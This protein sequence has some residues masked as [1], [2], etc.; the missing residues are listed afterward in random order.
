[1]LGASQTEYTIQIGNDGSASW[2]VTQ[3][4]NGNSSIE[5]PE[6]LQNRITLLVTASENA[7]GRTMT[8]SVD[9][10]TFTASGSYV[11]AEYKFQWENFSRIEG[12]QI[13]IGDVFQAPDFFSQL[14]GDGAVYMGYPPE[15]VVVEPILPAPSVQNDSIQSLGWLGTKDFN[16]NTRI[17]LEEK[18][19]TTGLFGALEESVV[20]AAI[21]G[22]IA[23]GSVGF[24]VFRYNKRKK[25]IGSEAAEP[26]GFPE[27][28]SDEERTVKLIKSSGGSLYQ[29]A[30]TDQFGFSKAK[31]SQ[32][33]AALEHEGI[34][35]RYKK[36][37]DKIVVLV[38]DSKD[39]TS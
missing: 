27:I 22:A 33:L 1:V 38:E 24:Y 2:T 19:A 31:T 12:D 9:S 15:Y 7:T 36:G 17:V 5:T 6:T 32:L 14:Y 25:N 10:L 8:A 4:L 29:S 39:E 18:S 30:I 21:F 13:M 3:T 35:R 23:A 26:R 20:L 37:R 34:I 16:G 28:E 11:E